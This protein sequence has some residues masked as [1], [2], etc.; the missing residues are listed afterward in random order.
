MLRVTEE[1]LE[2]RRWAEC[3][4][5][6]PCRDEA[7]GAPALA[8]P[9]QPCPG[10]REVGWAEFEAAFCAGRCVLVYDDGP[11]GTRFF[12]GSVEAARAFVAAA[13]AAHGGQAYA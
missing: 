10:G 7:T 6:R 5:A 9:A 8:S 1:V 4:G 3:R 2:V 12:L 13:E 11:G